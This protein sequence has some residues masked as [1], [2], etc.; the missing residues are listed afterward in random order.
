MSTGTFLLCFVLRLYTLNIVL[1]D[2]DLDKLKYVSFL[3]PSISVKM[4]SVS[5]QG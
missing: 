1:F 3:I 5:S 2:S 4:M